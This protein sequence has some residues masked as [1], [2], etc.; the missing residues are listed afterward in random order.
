MSG[1]K[2]SFMYLRKSPRK[3]FLPKEVGMEVGFF[4]FEVE[5]DIL[6]FHALG[7]LVLLDGASGQREEKIIKLFL[8]LS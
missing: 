6:H 8:P 4:C 2:R 7:L 3:I 5:F 1:E